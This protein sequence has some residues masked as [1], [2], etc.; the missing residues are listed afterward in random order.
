MRPGVSVDATFFR[1]DY[2][3]Q[4]VPASLAGGVGAILTNG[5]ATLH[6]GVELRAQIDSAPITGSAHDTY[7]RVAYTYLPTARI[8]GH[9]VQQHSRLRRHQRK[10]E[11]A[12]LRP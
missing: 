11:P 6:Q 12:A 10:R 4:I 8:H 3:N 1:M 9:P 2:E 7:L 5:G